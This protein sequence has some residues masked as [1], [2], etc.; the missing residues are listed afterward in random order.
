MSVEPDAAPADIAVVQKGLRAFS[1]RPAI[2]AVAALLAGCSDDRPID[3]TPAGSFSFAIFGDGPYE[4]G[5]GPKF[6]RVIADVNR[7]DVQWLIHVGDIFWFPCS[8][9]AYEERRRDLDR[10]VH[11]VI[12]TPGDN[13]WTDCHG[14]KQGRHDP[15]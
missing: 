11:A 4:L 14:K 1:V 13:E 15:L 2:V 12:Y 6:R 8:D 9:E 10:I 7:S 5:E 3:P